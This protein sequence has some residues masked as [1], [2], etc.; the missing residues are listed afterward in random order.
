MSRQAQSVSRHGRPAWSLGLL[1]KP[2]GMTLFHV[3]VLSGLV[4]ILM[5][6]SSV[7]MM[8]VYDRVLASQRVP[9]LVAI[10]LIALGAYAIFWVLDLLRQRIVSYLGERVEAAT[11]PIVQVASIDV[12]LK[13]QNASTKSLQLFRDMESLRAFVGGPGPI[14]FFDLPWIPLYLGLIFILHPLLGW[15]T[16]GGALFSIGLTLL[17]EFSLQPTTEALNNLS[18]RNMIA[19]NAQRG[20]EVLHAH[21]MAGNIGSNGTRPMATMLPPSARP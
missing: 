8:Q 7:Y 16:V 1:L 17:T 5:L 11:M 19:E 6:T 10:S 21:G 4:N 2:A 3:A 20:A 18:R 15:I 12:Q 9:T 13:N 14:A